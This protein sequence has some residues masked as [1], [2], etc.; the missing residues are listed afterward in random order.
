MQ[1]H[2]VAKEMGIKLEVEH[3]GAEDE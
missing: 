1:T 3:K 2:K